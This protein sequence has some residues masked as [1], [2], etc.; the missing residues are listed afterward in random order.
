MVDDTVHMEAMESYGWQASKGIEKFVGDIIVE[1]M[2]KWSK[3]LGGRNYG[4]L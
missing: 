1:A 2:M 3:T 4:L